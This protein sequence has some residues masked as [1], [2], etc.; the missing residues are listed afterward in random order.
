VFA[1]R[2]AAPLAANLRAMV[3]GGALRAY[4]PQNQFLSLIGTADGRAV[5]SRGRWAWHSRLMWIWKNAIHRRFM[6]H[7]G[8]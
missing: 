3:A 4:R 7:F 5:A 2:M 6:R 1:V 8:G